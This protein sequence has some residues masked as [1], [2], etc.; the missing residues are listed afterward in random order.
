MKCSTFLIGTLLSPVWPLQGDTREEGRTPSGMR[1]NSIPSSPTCQKWDLNTQTLGA[2]LVTQMWPSFFRLA[3]LLPRDLLEINLT[4]GVLLQN[5]N[6]PNF[7][8][9]DK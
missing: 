6:D 9:I 8:S 4:H 2:C 3:M 7:E 5:N 1:L